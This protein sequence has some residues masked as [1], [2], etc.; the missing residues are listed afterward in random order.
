MDISQ[1]SYW[2]GMVDITLGPAMSF[3]FA[4]AQVI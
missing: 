2:S 1:F 3:P 4:R